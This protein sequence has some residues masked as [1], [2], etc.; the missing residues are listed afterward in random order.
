MLKPTQGWLKE[1]GRQRTD[2]THVL[3]ASRILRR[4]EVVGET[5]RHTLNVLAGVEPVGRHSLHLPADWGGRYGRRIAEYR[6]PKGKAEREQYAN[7]VGADGWRI[8]EALAQ[9]ATPAW[10]CALPAVVTLRQVW[11]QQYHPK[12]PKDPKG[13]QGTRVLEPGARTRIYPRRARSTTP[14]MTPRH[15]L[16]RNGRAIGSG[17]RRISRRR[18]I[19]SSPISVS[20]QSPRWAQLPTR[21][22]SLPSMSN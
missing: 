19:P 7:Q 13:T 15:A 3:A 21:E 1:R 9:P 6:L 8:L 5:L 10:L 4:V 18:V 12:D 11:A 16:A 17:I 22:R 20:R 14:P 2:S